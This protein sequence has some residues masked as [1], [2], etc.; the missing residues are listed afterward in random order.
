M[1]FCKKSFNKKQS[2]FHTDAVPINFWASGQNLP[3]I[4]MGYKKLERNRITRFTLQY[5]TL[6]ITLASQYIFY[7][8]GT[9]WYHNLREMIYY[10]FEVLFSFRPP[11]GASRVKMYCDEIFISDAIIRMVNL[12]MISPN[13]LI[14]FL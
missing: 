5:I 10:L 1:Y 7:A 14:C 6:L 3:D 13:E 2:F 9:K 4:R 8:G 11:M 12:E